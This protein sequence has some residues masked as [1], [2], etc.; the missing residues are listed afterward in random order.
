MAN[1]QLQGRAFDWAVF[2]RIISIIRPYRSIYF[3]SLLLVV[4]LSVVTPL[5]PFL[6]QYT[7]D[8]HVV[9]FNEKGLIN[10]T[11]VMVVLL[12]LESLVRYAFT[13]ASS[14]LGQSA[15][16]DLR[17]Q[18]F[19][20]L[21]RMRLSF[22]DKTPI[23]QLTTRTISDIETIADVFSQGFF[24]IIGDILQLVAILGFMLYTDWKLTLISLSTLPLLLIASY[25]F[26]ESVKASFQDVRK[27]VANL[28]SFMQE[29]ISG[30]SIVQN[31][32]REKAEYQKFESINR[33]Q[34]D[35]NLRSVFAYSVFFPVVD[36]ITAVSLGLLVWWGANGALRHEV[37]LGAIIAFIQYVNMF[38]R[39]IRMLADRFNSLQMGIVASERVFNLL[40]TEEKIEDKGTKSLKGIKGDVT[41]REVQFEYLPGQPVLN[42]VSFQLPAGKT[43][44]LVGP[45]G[46]GKSSI[47][48]VLSRFYEYQYG[49]VL[50]D[51]VNIRDYKLEELQ[52]HIGIIL[53]DVFLFS[54][55]V[56]DNVSLGHPGVD[57]ETVERIAHET[58]II[59]FIDRLPG[60]F[61]YQVQE[62]GYA[63]SAGQRQ[64]IAFLRAMVFNPEILIL[65]E[66]TSAIDSETELI[67]QD[68]T[69]AITRNRSCIIIAHRLS[70]IRNSHEILV[71]E[72][73]QITERG[74]HEQLTVLEGG[75]YRK[76][77]QL[78]FVDVE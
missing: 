75:H 3:L 18:V 72:R 31:F 36:I 35:A 47:I 23:G 22:F 66:A 21:I 11:I 33:E 50:L 39:P 51:G 67:L 52:K 77:Y 13:Y 28:N 12:I 16:R 62:R 10:M 71:L 19:N 29:Q 38:F 53:Q 25:I 65:D 44:A 59:R 70:T 32:Y 42:K 24:T 6:I 26:K 48:A 46:A 76:L 55:S 34:R 68:A 1:K 4:L 58:G 40:D 63:L 61:D 20:H 41:F 5:R 30:M 54:G 45:T 78:Q 60:R 73:G 15:I 69:E 56:F 74:T 57:L 43:M 2:K 37:S 27:Y 14:W 49:E 8:T 17:Q 9:N 64:L 7:I